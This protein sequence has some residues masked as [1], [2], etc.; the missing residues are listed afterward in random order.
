MKY[1]FT[2]LLVGILF[3]SGTVSAQEFPDT[4]CL[5]LAKEFS[6][7]PDSLTL[8]ELERLRFCVQQTLAHREKNLKGEILK[9]TIIEPPSP[10]DGPVDTPLLAD[11]K[12]LKTIP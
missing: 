8:Q 11:P 12:T 5:T 9:G 3:S 6:E 10:S 7:T 2:G 4:R 1:V